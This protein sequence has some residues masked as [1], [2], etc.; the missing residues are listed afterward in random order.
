M[1]TA[2]NSVGTIFPD[3]TVQSSAWT[4]VRA[5]VFTSSGTFT[6]PSGITAVKVTVIGGGGAGATIPRYYVGSGGGAGGTAIRYITGLTPNMSITVTV[7]A[8]GG[9]SSFGSYCSATGGSAG[10]YDSGG[11]GVPWPG[12]AGGVG[13]GGTINITGGA[14][15]Y[16]VIL[17]VP[18]GPCSVA[19]FV[20]S[21][22]GG[23]SSGQAGTIG[24]GNS[25]SPGGAGRISGMGG[26]GLYLNSTGVAATGY[27]NGGGGAYSISS[28][29]GL[30]G[31]AGSPGIVIVEW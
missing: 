13:S 10:T 6:V 7:G 20:M 29:V 26:Y 3:D 31:G 25:Y 19:G 14:G 12:G 21:G 24:I 2:L 16:T 5:Q 8:A 27:G 11:S 1:T 17:N 28:S 4:G 30:S 22:S 23:G 15:G 18:T 9:T